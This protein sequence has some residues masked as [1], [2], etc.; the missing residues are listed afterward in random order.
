[1]TNLP[2]QRT[3]G[4]QTAA[5]AALQQHFDASAKNFDT[6][7]AFATDANRFETLSQQ[8]PY[9]FADLSKN[10]LDAATQALLMDLARQS[11]VEAHRDAMFAGEKIN[12]A[13]N[14]AV[15]HWLLR[16]SENVENNASNM[17]LAGVS[18]ASLA[19]N[20]EANIKTDLALVHQT[21]T[22]MLA[23]AE[24]IRADA[25]ITDIVNIGI[26]GSDL[27]PLMAVLALDSF[28]T[29]GKRLHFVSNVDGHELAAVLKNLK[30]ENTLFLVAS[31]TFTTIETM[32]NALSAK[33]WFEANY[34]DKSALLVK[35]KGISR[36]FAA[37]T[38]NV[39][40][41]NNFGIST[42]FGF[43]DWVGGRYSMWS[44]IGLPIAIAIGAQGFKD[45]LAGASAMDEH[46][47]TAPLESNLPVKLG[48]LD[49]WYRNFH[50]FT[51]RCVAPYHSALKRLPAYLQQLEMESNGKQVDANGQLLPFSTSAVVWGEPGTN[52]QHAF[53]Q[54]LHQ[55]TDVVPVEFIAVKNARH[56]LPGHQQRLLANAVAQAQALMMG[57]ADAGG[58]KNFPGNRPSTTMLL[59]DLTP[60]SFG[61]LIALYE[62]RVFVAG[63]VWGINSFDQWGVELGKVLAVD[64]EKRMS[65]GD[66]AG[67]DGS[68]QGLLKRLKVD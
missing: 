58:H 54:M 27:G 34:G 42:T 61:A 7:D 41:A 20:N 2:N 6:R 37:L 46:F 43:W 53:F 4:D 18:I 26:G 32:T 11:G 59:E 10:R 66:M 16:T 39:A 49:V 55:G 50:G 31:K 30:A 3:R 35:D 24:Q 29:T 48:L 33:A 21:L 17:P 12:N 25:Q 63:S 22:P 52:G 51:S 1:M 9:V 47:R 56:S 44:A 38:T 5:W 23:Y 45:M 36:H 65:S 13:E 14:R 60:A 8:A 40:A 68:T 62:H 19:I 15:M 67:L 28:A 64:I 57:K